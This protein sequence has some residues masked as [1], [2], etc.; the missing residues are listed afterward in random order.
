MDLSLDL[1]EHGDLA[2]LIDGFCEK[3]DLLGDEAV[4][5]DR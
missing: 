3:E 5:C 2:R 1:G 4:V